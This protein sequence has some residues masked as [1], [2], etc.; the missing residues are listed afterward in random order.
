MSVSVPPEVA[1][2]CLGWTPS[3]VRVAIQRGLVPWGIAIKSN[4]NYHYDIYSRILA[5][6][7]N[8]PENEIEARVSA[9]REKSKRRAGRGE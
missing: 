2:Q 7:C 6:F 8:V 1:A 4:Q 5:E 9:W 3:R